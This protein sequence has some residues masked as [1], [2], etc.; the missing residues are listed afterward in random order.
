M[1]PVAIDRRRLLCN[2]APPLL[3]GI[4]YVQVV[5]PADQTE[6]LVF[7]IIEPDQVETGP[8]PTHMVETLSVPKAFAGLVEAV[9]VGGGETA[10]KMIPATAEY[11]FAT[12]GGDTHIVLYLKFDRPGDF[13]NY[14]LLIDD[15]AIDPFFNNVLFSFKQGCDTG[16]DCADRWKCP[17]DRLRD[18]E[19]D[20]LA[21]DFSSLNSALGDFAARYYPEWGERIPADVGVMITELFAALGDELSYV[22]DRFALEAYL[23]T[24]TQRRSLMRLARLV[25]YI[26]DPGRNSSCLLS[27]QMVFQ[28]QNS[29]AEVL[30]FADRLPFWA[31]PEGKPPIPFELGAGLWDEG[32]LMAHFSWNAMQI[33]LADAGEPCLPAGATELL[34]APTPGNLRL[35]LNSQIPAG[36][37]LGGQ[38]WVGR[39]MI[40]WSKPVDPSVPVRAWPIK[41]TEVDITAEDPLVLQGGNPTRLTRLKW[42]KSQAVPNAMRIGETVLLGNIAPAVAGLTTKDPEVFRVGPA[43]AVALPGA[44]LMPQAIEREGPAMGDCDRPP[45]ILHGMEASEAGGI[46]HVG[47]HDLMRSRVPEIR[48]YEKSPDIIEWSYVPSLLEA[49]ENDR[50]FTLDPGMWRAI[51]RYQRQGQTFVHSDYASDSGFTLRFGGGDFGRTPEIGSVF[52]VQ[53]RTYFGTDSNLGP[54]TITTID[55]PDG[56]LRKAALNVVDKVTNPLPA[57]GGVDAETA[58]R[59]R[60]NAPEFY[61]A[62]PLNAVRDEHFQ[63]IVERE[64]WVQKAGS[65]TRWTG[66]WL[67]HFITAD[68]VDAFAYTPEQRT[69]LRNIVNAVRMAGRDAVICD[70]RYAPLD[71]EISICVAPGFYD[72]QVRE[73]VINAL[74]GSTPENSAL[75]DPDNFTFGDPLRR[76]SIEA[77]VQAVPG[78]LGVVGI[79]VRRRGSVGWMPFTE[80]EISV[81]ANE[82][83]RLDNDPNYPERGS[84]NVRVTESA[85]HDKGC[86]CC[87][88]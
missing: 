69:R 81:A 33:Y 30:N 27:L 21:R 53:S 6:L 67:R 77:A 70:P 59:S 80:S 61:R 74:T 60:Q 31:T 34:L 25:D 83:I 63:E 16:F 5:N 8:G 57:T 58:E 44:E 84:L 17:P 35:P 51:V 82:I 9:A 43:S 40:L 4:D 10:S 20:Y 1:I 54:A 79:C 56:T 55:P 46:N 23:Q 29:V 49:D 42:D 41:I 36:G 14:R 76:A 66:S 12:I 3:T 26:P 48:L 50:V 11:R 24:A 68:P 15:P 45:A 73:A 75:F 13:S 87:T 22:Q 72:G 64:D 62:F 7:F 38:A 71:L 78:V 32:K 65:R 86:A 39:T 19:I 88:P 85:S 28:A 18:V 52:E 2:Q 37:L 47:E